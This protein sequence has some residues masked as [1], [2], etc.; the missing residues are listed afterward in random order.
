PNPSPL[1]PHARRRR[2]PGRNVA[3][4]GCKAV[5]WKNRRRAG[6]DGVVIRSANRLVA[7]PEV[8]G[9]SQLLMSR[10]PVQV[11]FLATDVLSIYTVSRF[12]RH[13]DS[14]SFIPYRKCQISE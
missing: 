14:F 12:T 1:A 13:W 3:Q 5:Q 9:T 4:S 6:S 8:L 10:Y 2:N 7:E 11:N